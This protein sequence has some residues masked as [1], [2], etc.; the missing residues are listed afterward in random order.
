MSVTILLILLTLL[1]RLKANQKWERIQSATPLQVQEGEA[2]NLLQR[3]LPK[4]HHLF[5]IKIFGPRFAPRNRDQVFL[6]TKDST[7]N[8]VGVSNNSSGLRILHVTSNTGVAA[9]WG[10][11]YYLKYYCNSHISWDTTRI[12]KFDNS[13]KW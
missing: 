1:P 7:L 3:L 9:I 10:I 12:G 5:S 13:V 4:H 8:D 2:E 6:I 11:N